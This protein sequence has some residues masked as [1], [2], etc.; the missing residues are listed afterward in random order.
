MPTPQPT[1]AELRKQLE[2][3]VANCSRPVT[4]SPPGTPPSLIG[5]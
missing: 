2:T 4:R 5:F 1:K 3:A